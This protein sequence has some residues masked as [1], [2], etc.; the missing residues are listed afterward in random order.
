MA[1]HILVSR[2]GPTSPSLE[3]QNMDASVNV[4]GTNEDRE[5]TMIDPI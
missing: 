5:L 3:L 1:S 4:T 2:S